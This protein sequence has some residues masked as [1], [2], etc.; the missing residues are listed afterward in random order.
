MALTAS[1][2]LVTRPTGSNRPARP[3]GS[4]R[5]ARRNP[6]TPA[7]IVPASADHFYIANEL[8]TQENAAAQLFGEGGV[9]QHPLPSLERTVLTNAQE[10][11]LFL[12]YNYC[13]FRVAQVAGASLK[14]TADASKQAA[15][16]LRAADER[17][18][19]L[20][21][22]NM[23]L[24]N[25]MIRNVQSQGTDY[26][27]L[28]SEGNLTLLN[29]VG[30][31][32][33]GR[34]FRFST[35]ACQAIHH[36]IALVLTRRRRRPWTSLCDNLDI[37]ANEEMAHYVEEIPM[38]IEMLSRNDAGLTPVELQV[39]RSRYAIHLS[40]G[41]AIS[42]PMTRQSM[43][44]EEIGRVVGVSKERIRQIERNALIKLRQTFPVREM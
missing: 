31:F 1:S 26:D 37:A 39:I 43:T 8:F 35:Y 20:V 6:G 42:D 17:R 29:A 33:V 44:R 4:A 10:K 38:V 19:R 3:A 11:A 40:T 27:E 9:E 7:E 23:G 34:G 32:D 36:A 21:E 14:P 22:C 15:L 18:D 28:L 12:E 2:V 5:P 41:V 30:K 24:V 13:R 16:W 25:M